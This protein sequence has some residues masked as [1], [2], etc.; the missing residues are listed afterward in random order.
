MC[1]VVYFSSFVIVFI[2]LEVNLVHDWE[3]G[4]ILHVLAKND[5]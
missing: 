2:S 5:M 3:G 4:C 1:N